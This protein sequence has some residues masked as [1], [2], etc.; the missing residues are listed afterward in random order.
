MELSNNELIANNCEPPATAITELCCPFKRHGKVLVKQREYVGKERRKKAVELTNLE[1]VR[2]TV[3]VGDFFGFQ[4][5]FQI[6]S[7]AE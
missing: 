2:K 1:K 4:I 7:R 3:V 5:C 6:F